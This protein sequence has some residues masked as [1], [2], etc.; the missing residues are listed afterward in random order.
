MPRHDTKTFREVFENLA[1]D[2]SRTTREKAEAKSDRPPQ[3][4]DTRPG[5]TVP[6]EPQPEDKMAGYKGN[7]KLV[8][9]QAD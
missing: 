5:E 9:K 3:S 7:E 8:G 4:Q 2:P 6:M 1:N